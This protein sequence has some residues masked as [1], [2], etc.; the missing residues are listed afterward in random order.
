MGRM[1]GA[2]VAMLL[3]VSG[4]ALAQAPTPPQP[5]PAP[6]QPAGLYRFTLTNGQVVD[7]YWVG[8]DANNIHVQTQTGVF[9]L[10]L[11]NVRMYAPLAPVAPTP[12][13]QPLPVR[14][15][16]EVKPSGPSKA[17]AGFG[18][19]ISAYLITAFVA[20]A[21]S[22]DDPDSK[23]GYLPILGPV[24]WTATDEDKFGNDGWDWLALFS[25][26]CQGA[27]VYGM[28]DGLGDTKTPPPKK[29]TITSGRNYGGI[30]FS[31]TF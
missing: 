9:S 4:V 24:L 20:R 18:I 28:I 17:K 13:P 2:L 19:F 7:G 5:Q 25:T 16:V 23:L 3:C 26:F 10:A 30:S 22:D 31:G 14:D 29:V 1:R 8:G 11:V 6:Q 27:G 15:A 12:P 21:R